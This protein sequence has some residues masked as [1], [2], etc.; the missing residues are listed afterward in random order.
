VFRYLVVHAIRRLF[1]HRVQTLL[2]ILG[3]TIGI[4]NII[5]LISISETAKHQTVRLLDAFGV[6]TMFVT[7]YFDTSAGPFGGA[8][9]VVSALHQTDLDTVRSVPGVGTA[10]GI[11]FSPA[12][13]GYKAKRTFTVVVGTDA[14]YPD[15]RQYKVARG[16]FFTQDEVAE[17]ARVCVLGTT[18]WRHIFGD[19]NPVGESVVV[20]GERYEVVG[21]MEQYGFIG[22]EDFDDRVFAPRPVVQSELLNSDEVRTILLRK[23]PSVTE[24]GL[25]ADITS[26]LR[27]AHGLKPDDPD[28]FKVLSMTAVSKLRDKT[29]DIFNMV[30]LGVGTV[31]LIVAGIGI[32]NVMLMSVMERTKE[33]GIRKTVGARK[34]EILWQFLVESLIQSF[35]GGVLGIAIG[36]AGTLVLAA[37]AHWEAYISPGT[38]VLA[39]LFSAATGLVF[40]MT[41]AIRAASLNPIDS[42]RY[43]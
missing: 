30:L 4:A 11:A 27:K 34:S 19:A 15:L 31:A 35:I 13:V 2:S 36:V 9:S 37:K 14:D 42:V 40:G 21:L 8:A 41:P 18:A 10:V 12:F 32:M 23:S 5:A 17:K 20:K 43:E 22:F 25:T 33:I 16:R 39:V 6:N 28:D 7:P 38:I 26:A 24:E 29:F 1:T 3:I